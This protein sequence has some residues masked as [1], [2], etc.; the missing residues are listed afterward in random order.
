VVVAVDPA[1]VV[2]MRWGDCV[3]AALAAVAEDDTTIEQLDEDVAGQVDVVGVSRPAAAKRLSVGAGFMIAMAAACID[4][5]TVTSGDGVLPR[6]RG[7]SKAPNFKYDGPVSVI[8]L[9][10]DVSDPVVRRRVERQWAAVFRLRRALQRDAAHRCRAYWA[11]RRERTPDQKGLRARLGLSRKGIAAAA[12]RHIEASGWMRDHLTKAVGLHVAD[13]VWQTVDRHLFADASGRRAGPPR[14]GSWWDFTRIPGRA[15]SHTKATPV[16]ESWRLV[17]TLD[18]HLA[19][20]RHPQLPGAVSTATEPAG[21]PAGTSILAQPARLAAPARPASGKWADHRG[22]LAVVFTGLPGGDLV[23]PVR[24][25]QG[26]GQWAHLCH[27]LVDP[28]V[29]H[30]IDV[31]RVRDRKAPGGWRYYAHLLIHRSGYQSP[32]TRAR[33]GEIPT[34]RHAGVDANVSNLSVAS[35]SSEHPEQLLTGRITCDAEQQLTSARAAAKARARLRALDRSRRNTNPDQYAPSV[36]QQQRAARRAPK[37]LRARQITN[38]GGPRHSRADG[39]PLRAYRRDTLSRSYQRT[40]DD[41]ASEARAASQ[42][43]HARAREVAGRLV[44]SH[45]SSITVE[46]CS[47]ST[48]ARLWGKRI[49]L[50]GPGMLVAALA[51]ECAA[52]GGRLDRVG[53]RSTA[54]SQHCLCGARAP[55]TLAQR[56]HECPHCGLHGDRDIVSAALAACVSL[57]DPDDPRTARV[58]YQLAHALRASLASQQEWEGS[59]NRHQPPPPDGVGSARTGSRHPVASAE[60]VALGPPP[61]RPSPEPGR[62]GTS[63][64][65]PAPKLIG[66]V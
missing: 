28:N 6:R 23:L 36:R 43:K 24:L 7:K 13:E 54:L 25:P 60:Q 8:R 2:A 27:F 58:D 61:N 34:D 12:K 1:G 26:A 65:Q 35:F 30:K 46:D 14:V 53:T 11:A 63:R 44:A 49:Q 55:K 37:G 22:G 3:E 17:G 66:A 39:V 64:K 32:A 50:F 20:Y 31:V 38:P 59:V 4:T 42:A 48:W 40:R 29:W 56:T 9:E 19:A 21:R 41:R 10:L 51:R 47:I 62:R 18:G 52:A 33:R 5:T 57:A 45:G 15:R 16:W